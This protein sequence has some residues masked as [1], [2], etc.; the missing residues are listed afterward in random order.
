MSD[1]DEHL[2]ELEV[3]RRESQISH[4]ALDNVMMDHLKHSAQVIAGM[5]A[6]D[7]SDD[8]ALLQAILGNPT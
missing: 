2:A 3:I 5:D 8:E 6:M 4:E 7:T 1:T